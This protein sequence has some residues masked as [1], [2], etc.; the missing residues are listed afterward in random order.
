M[1][2]SAI[3]YKAVI[4]ILIFSTCHMSITIQKLPDNLINQIAAGEVVENPACCIKELI[5][6]SIDA[7][8]THIDVFIKAGGFLS[9]LISDNGHGIEEEQILTAFER[10]TTSKLQKLEDLQSHY[11]MGFRGEALASIAS[12]SKVVLKTSTHDGSGR[13]VELHGGELIKSEAISMKKGTCVEIKDLFYNTPARKKFQ[14]SASSSTSEI[15]K[16]LMALSL[17]HPQI[18]FRLKSEASFLLETLCPPESDFKKAFKKRLQDIF[19]DFSIDKGKFLELNDPLI[20][21]YGYLAPFEQHSHTRKGQYFIVNNRVVDCPSISYI[22]SES[23]RTHLPEKR[24]FQ[25]VFHMN[26]DPKW[27][28][29]NIHPQKKEIRFAEEAYIRDVFKRLILPKEASFEGMKMPQLTQIPSFEYKLN[30]QK[31]LAMSE[32]LPKMAEFIYIKTVGFY[33][34][35]MLI[36]SKELKD[37]EN[38]QGLVLFDVKSAFIRQKKQAF[39]TKALPSQGLL[40]PVKFCHLPLSIEAKHKLCEF[41]FECDN[42]GHLL[43][44]PLDLDTTLAV[45][46]AKDLV[47]LIESSASDLELKNCYFESAY[48]HTSVG[49]EEA[50]KLLNFHIKQ[51]SIKQSSFFSLIKDQKL[52]EIFYA[53]TSS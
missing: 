5:E 37:F 2:K 11:K 53:H 44:H 52:K 16:Q 32:A 42:F 8:A 31:P 19:P 39:E 41:G 24:F 12:C 17:A 38:E 20:S 4:K 3:A 36:E 45:S 25:G 34:P 48:R 10:H 49:F 51:G 29:I 6:N 13:L 22:L 26:I 30:L 15:H 14:K 46:I 9:I 1:T 43:S 47:S 35:Y 27:I 50:L 28:D 23:L 40:I 18:S 33:S 21:I 7:G